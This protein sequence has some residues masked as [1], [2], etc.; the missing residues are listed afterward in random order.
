MSTA[1]PVSEDKHS[2]DETKPI[3]KSTPSSPIAPPKQ[4]ETGRF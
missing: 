2:D 4:G 3:S 1:S